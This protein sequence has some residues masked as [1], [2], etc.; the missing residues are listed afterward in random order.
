MTRH[1]STI[2]KRV[3]RT[4]GSSYRSPR[5]GRS[6]LISTKWLTIGL[7][8]AFVVGA[9]LVWNFTFGTFNP[10]PSSTSF[11]ENTVTCSSAAGSCGAFRIYSANLTV[12]STA[13]IVSQI[14]SIGLNTTSSE[15]MTSARVY[16]DSVFVGSV[17]GTFMPGVP[18]SVSFGIPTTLT[19][20]PDASYTIEVEGFFGNQ[21]STGN[22]QSVAVVAR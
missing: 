9:Y 19:I 10:N 22:L 2:R 15:P 5:T 4:S 12:H 6:G 18:K 3:S 8:M 21:Q 1:G 11:A 7:C 17:D 14:L 20:T 13:D 16:V